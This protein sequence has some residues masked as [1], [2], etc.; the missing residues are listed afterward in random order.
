MPLIFRG[1]SE[2]HNLDDVEQIVG[3]LGEILATQTT[4]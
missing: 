2:N 1:A 4:R 3:I